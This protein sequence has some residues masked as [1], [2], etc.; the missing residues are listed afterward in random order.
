MFTVTILLILCALA[1][2]LMHALKPGVVPLWIAV[3][4]IIVAILVT[5]LPIR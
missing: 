3:L 5:A 4:F 1:A 2:L